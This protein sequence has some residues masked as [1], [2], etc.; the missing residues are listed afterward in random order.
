MFQLVKYRE[1]FAL[2]SFRTIT[3]LGEIPSEVSSVEV[4]GIGSFVRIILVGV[5][6]ELCNLITAV[7]DRNT[8]L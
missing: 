2:N 3:V 4:T 7:N 8:G 1:E 6:V 5:I